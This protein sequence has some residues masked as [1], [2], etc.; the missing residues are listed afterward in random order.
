MLTTIIGTK[1]EKQPKLLLF[2]YFIGKCA[3]INPALS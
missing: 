1:K 2:F 3:G